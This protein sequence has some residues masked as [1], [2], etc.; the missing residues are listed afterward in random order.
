MLD[1]PLAFLAAG[2]TIEHLRAPAVLKLKSHSHGPRANLGHS[3]VAFSGWEHQVAYDGWIRAL[4]TMATSYHSSSAAAIF[5][6]KECFV[7]TGGL[8]WNG[9]T[10]CFSSS[11]PSGSLLPGGR[12]GG[13]REKNAL[14]QLH[15]LDFLCIIHTVCIKSSEHWY[16]RGPYLFPTADF[17]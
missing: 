14:G 13:R 8:L 15:Q 1:D 9:C 11:I 7:H 16:S 10:V 2:L 5:Y 4:V 3:R 12:F 6:P 17:L